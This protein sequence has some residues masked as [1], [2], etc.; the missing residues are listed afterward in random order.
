M[1]R[2]PSRKAEEERKAEQERLRAARHG[3]GARR[4]TEGTA[5]R[6]NG[7]PIAN[8]LL[9]AGAVGVGVAF[10]EEELL[11]GVLLGAAAALTPNLLPRL[12]RAL[13]PVLKGVIRAGY[14]FV[15]TTREALAEAGEQFEDVVA[16]VRSERT[17][18]E[19]T[20]GE[21]SEGA[22]EPHQA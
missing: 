6:P 5:A 2:E 7:S 22:A 12:G 15:E 10:I 21:V 18:V 9:I 19:P 13:R 11:G 4:R 3:E 1:P 20:S 17:P 8:G 14:G 16:E